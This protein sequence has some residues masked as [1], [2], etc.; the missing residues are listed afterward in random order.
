MNLASANLI[1]GIPKNKIHYLLTIYFN[2]DILYMKYLIEFYIMTRLSSKELYQ[3]TNEI[4]EASYKH[5]E[6]DWLF[7][8]NVAKKYEAKTK[9]IDRQDVR[10][11]IMIEL[12]KAQK[13]D[14]KELP[15]L[16]AYRIASLVVALYWRKALKHPSML[17]LEAE[18]DDGNALLETVADDSAIDIEAWLD[19]SIWLLG[20]PKKL[21]RIARKKL[22]RQ[23]LNEAE[24][25][26]LYRY[27]KQYEQKNLL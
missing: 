14:G 26:Y 23:T 15:E 11:D 8:Y 10:H 12:A 7:Y 20:C 9:A 6:G 18:N 22:E 3:E 27:R 4:A 25:K 17:S 2:N 19:A 16:R 21:I 24:R 5:L 13:R 1:I